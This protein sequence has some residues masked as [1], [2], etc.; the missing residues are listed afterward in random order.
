MDLDAIEDVY[1]D[2]LEAQADEYRT[3]PPFQ[4]Q[5]SYRN[6]ARLA[7]KILPVMSDDE[8]EDDD[9]NDVDDHDCRGGRTR[10]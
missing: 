8:I 4:L 6:M 5:G 9:G 1:D 7:E 2:T 3:E 10:R